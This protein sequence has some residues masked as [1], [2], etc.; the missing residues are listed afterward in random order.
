VNLRNPEAEPRQSIAHARGNAMDMRTTQQR[1]PHAHSDDNKDEAKFNAT[2][3]PLPLSPQK[4]DENAMSPSRLCSLRQSLCSHP[5]L[6]S[7]APMQYRRLRC[8]GATFSGAFATALGRELT[9]TIEKELPIL[10]PAIVVGVDPTGNSL[11]HADADV[12]VAGIGVF[13]VEDL[14]RLEAGNFAVYREFV[15]ADFVWKGAFVELLAH[16]TGVEWIDGTRLVR[17][18]AHAVQEPVAVSSKFEVRDR[19][20]LQLDVGHV[21]VDAFKQR[22]QHKCLIKSQ[23]F[24]YSLIRSP[25]TFA[26]FRLVVCL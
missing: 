18:G 2:T 24:R 6:H 14:V 1:C 10:L 12:R 9:R 19:D 13:D 3:R 26:A 20:V 5:D 8:Q 22:Q 17:V 25:Y 16:A 4:L 15:V 11:R 21:V 7:L 23:Q